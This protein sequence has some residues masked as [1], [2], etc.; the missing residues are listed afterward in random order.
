LLIVQLIVAAANNGN[1][2]L[3]VAVTYSRFAGFEMKVDPR[4]RI[5]WNTINSVT[6]KARLTRQEY[7]LLKRAYLEEVGPDPSSGMHGHMAWAYM[8]FEY[9]DF[10]L[11]QKK[12][13]IEPEPASSAYPAGAYKAWG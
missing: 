4:F 5:G 6:D 13:T 7:E 2:R 1:I 12:V 9:L 3:A 8:N 10:Y 11:K